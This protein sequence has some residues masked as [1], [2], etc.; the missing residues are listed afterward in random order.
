MKRIRIFSGF[1][2][3]FRLCIF[4]LQYSRIMRKLFILILILS[5]ASSGFSQYFQTGQDPAS[6]KWRQINT[7]DFQV[8]YPS[9]FESKAQHL[10][11][12]L[13][14]IYDYGSYTMNHRPRK[15]SL[16]LHT[17][18]NKSNGLVAVAP[19]RAEFFTIP[20][21]SGYA[22]DWLE[23]LALHEFRHVVQVDKIDSSL[24][25]IIKF[26]LGEQGTAL[27]IGAFLP[28]WFLEGDAV[29][30]ETA[31]SNYG[32]GRFPSFLMETKA[33]V[34]QK[35]I[36]SFDKAY[37]GSFKD[38]VPD[39]YNLGYQIVGNARMRYGASLWERAVKNAGTKPV[40][41]TPVRNVIKSVTG[42][43]KE[44][45]YHN[46][47]DSLRNSWISEDKLLKTTPFTLIT[48][49]TR[50]FTSYELNFLY[51]NDIVSYKTSFNTIPRFVKITPEGKEYTLF[52]PGKIFN[53]SVSLN[54]NL[55]V[56]SERI[57]D[58]R[59]THSS[60]SLVR[61]LNLENSQ[62]NEFKTGITTVAPTLSP[63]N[64]MLAFSET[65]LENN[66]FLSIYALTG[67]VI[68]KYHTPSN[69]FFLSPCWIDSTTIAVVVLTGEG[70][71][72]AYYH[73]K[74]DK[75]EFPE[76][77]DMGNIQ[78]LRFS[79]GYLYFVGSFSG[80]NELY[81][82]DKLQKHVFRV[83]VSR[84]GTGYPAVDNKGKRLIVS[85][86]TADGYRLVELP[87]S[88]GNWEP[89]N[90]VTP[91]RYQLAE[92]LK[93][94][95]KGI[96]DLNSND[97]TDYE[98]KKYSKT[99]HLFQFHSWAPAYIDVNSNSITPGL[100]LMSQNKL[101]TS[102][103]TLGYRYN[104]TEETGRFFANYTYK[105]FYPVI[106]IETS[107]GKRASDYYLI[108]ETRD[109]FGNV[110]KRDTAIKR[111]TW[112]ETDLSVNLTLPLNFSKGRYNRLFQPGF[113]YDFSDILHDTSTPSTFYKGQVHSFSY[114][115]YFHMLMNE[116][117]QDLYPP[118]GFIFDFKYRNTPLTGRNLGDIAGGQS[119]LYLPGLL[120]NHGIKVYNGFQKK[121]PGEDY[122][123]FGDLVRYPRGWTSI[124]NNNMYSFG[125]D[126]KF[127]IFYP[128]WRFAKAVYIQRIKCS[129]FGDYAFL[130]GN[131]Y[132]QGK[133]AG[134]FNKNISSY[135]AELTGD[136][137]LLRFYAPV[138]MGLRTG[139]MP[140]EGTFFK[141]LLSVNFTSF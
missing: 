118:F 126:Y 26:L 115:L 58:I 34:I 48:K 24:P 111:F 82:F 77:P 80:R 93:A 31:L 30:T 98:S 76:L 10:A 138:E 65:D 92:S 2:I 56:W 91:A 9:E 46:I 125:I 47:Y 113:L 106:K 68:K 87:L 52:V 37:T 139:Y 131:L 6:I 140:G 86:Y 83:A 90:N 17:R 35:G 141:F 62:L 107:S 32:R 27:A 120:P 8:I 78:Q 23:Q 88:S 61:I 33:Q 64:T 95:E 57:P 29:V 71:K 89:L 13:E 59:W 21:Q 114:N 45:L 15:I 79:A 104:M 38:Y 20:D 137:N 99:G 66:Y 127:P 70:K 81:A 108:T 73:I 50:L 101:G 105:G 136:L 112:N 63:G 75:L 84:F 74:D 54:E 36:Y 121:N 7:P 132:K 18:N 123:S 28:F 134:T 85:D 102:Q 100:S 55:L 51:K 49:S 67:Q 72:I 42:L 16:I 96:P 109:R 53:E 1:F 116:S 22:Q 44:Q 11:H 103:A 12:L 14:K 122:H 129:L 43:N 135:G 40:S 130:K 119:I 5:A 133:I 60:Y 124:Q 3:F 110:L 94:Q 41:I 69:N 128:D 4:P 117:Y 39:H 19:K 97:T 25:F